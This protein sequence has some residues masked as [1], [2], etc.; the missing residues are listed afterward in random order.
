MKTL[1]EIE[2]IKR[3]CEQEFLGRP[4]VTGV[5]VVPKTLEGFETK[6]G[7]RITVGG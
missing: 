5:D 2:R 7:P 1:E 6:V 3:S 4:G